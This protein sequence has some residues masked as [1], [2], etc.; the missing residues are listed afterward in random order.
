MVITGLSLFCTV[1]TL[2]IHH[3]DPSRPMPPFLHRALIQ[4]LGKLLCMTNKKTVEPKQQRSSE[5]E[6]VGAETGQEKINQKDA[7]LQNGGNAMHQEDVI[8]WRVAAIDAIAGDVQLMARAKMEEAH[9]EEQG[10]QWQLAARI[11]D[12][13][14]LYISIV[15]MLFLTVSLVIVYPIIEM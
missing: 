5:Q 10:R 8:P 15:I 12:R 7:R 4:R 1:A 13:L 2:S 11:L 14:F 9:E 6:L 3:M